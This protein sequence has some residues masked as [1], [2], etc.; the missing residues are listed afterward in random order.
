MQ[1]VT[2]EANI[3]YLNLCSKSIEMDGMTLQPLIE[4]KVMT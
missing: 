3:I 1:M 2:S 4:R